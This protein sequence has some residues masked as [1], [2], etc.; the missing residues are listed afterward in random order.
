MAN[1]DGATPGD[2]TTSPFGD[3]S[4]AMATRFGGNDFQKNPAGQSPG[5]RGVNFVKDPSGS[6][7]T[8]DQ[9]GGNDFNRSPAGQVRGGGA[10]AGPQQ[11]GT[12]QDINSGDKAEGPPDAAQVATPGG[13]QISRRDIGTV[14]GQAVHKPFK[15][16]G[17]GAP[18]GGGGGAPE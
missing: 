6:K 17:G 14:A 8:G 12:D 4:G 16:G 1:E 15:L 5:G 2:G 9:H 3:G 18:A 7:P 11:S 13:E 10:M